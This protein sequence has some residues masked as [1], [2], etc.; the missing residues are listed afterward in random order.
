MSHR[1]KGL[2]WYQLYLRIAKM[3]LGNTQKDRVQV[4][5]GDRLYPVD[6]AFENSGQKAYLIVNGIEVINE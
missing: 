4:K 6:L 5:L 3:C 2:T 1:S